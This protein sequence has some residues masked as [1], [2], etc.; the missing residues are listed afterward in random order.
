MATRMKARAG[1]VVHLSHILQ[2]RLV[3]VSASVMSIEELRRLLRSVIGIMGAC[4]LCN[5]PAL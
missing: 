4:K 2:T 1:T 3:P 5:P